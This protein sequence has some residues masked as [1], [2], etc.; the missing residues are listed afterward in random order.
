[1]R[2]RWLPAVV[3]LLTVISCGSTVQEHGPASPSPV[4]SSPVATVPATAPVTTSD[5]PIPMSGPGWDAH[6]IYVGVMT[7][8]DAA[9]VSRGL[10]LA[11][12]NP[13]NQEADA[14]AIAASINKAGGLYG[15][16]LVLEF[17]NES[18]FSM[19]ANPDSQAAAACSHFTEDRPV[20]ALINA[21]T[22]IDTPTFKS[23]FASHHVPLFDGSE[24]PT[25]TTALAQL[26]GDVVSVLSP[27]Y[28]DVA[29]TLVDRLKAE[30]YFGGWN[31][32]TGTSG[33]APVKVG[34]LTPNDP[35]G[36]EAAKLL[37]SALTGASYPPADVFSF[38]A[39]GA[40]SGT[41][42]SAVLQFKTR[43][44]THVIGTGLNSYLFMIA[45][46]SQNYHPRYGVSTFN[47]PGILLQGSVNKAQLG[48]A[49][50]IG[51]EPTVDVDAARDPGIVSSGER[52]CLRTLHAAGQNF[53]SQRFP[54]A[55][56]LFSCD[57]FGL[58]RDSALA[59]DGLSAAAIIHG[60]ALVGPR[61]V[62]AETFTSGLGP[63]R[64]ALA[65]S[66]RDRGFSTQ[67]ECFRYLSKTDYP[68]LAARSG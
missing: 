34:I 19:L 24:Q 66:A 11:D 67:C 17:Y 27:S 38:S 20:V 28:T 33:S 23:C 5:G 14:D 65:G 1:V 12:I 31:T 46:Q 7:E 9:A 48:G 62:P 42:A 22:I 60:V 64:F 56:G 52:S 50:G 35:T 40:G 55:V 15:R 26:G 49:L 58:L 37:S 30:G 21:L 41:E 25:D 36:A 29:P 39:S 59:G 68:I 47:A 44:I 8:N 51:T 45:A 18:T 43:G 6:N 4:A 54:E 63:G 32:A 10:G 57:V 16:M 13:G 3:G 61:F 53:G 2:R